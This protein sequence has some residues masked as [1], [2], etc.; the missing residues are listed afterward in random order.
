MDNFRQAANNCELHN[1]PFS[2]YEFTFDNGQE[3]VDNV[4]CRLDR[5]LVNDGWLSVFD[6]ARGVNLDREWSDHAPIK[7]AMAGTEGMEVKRDKPFR[8]EQVWVGEEKCEKVIDEAW[9]IGGPTVANKLAFCAADLKA[10]SDKEFG[11]KFRELRKKRKKLKELNKGGL[12]AAQ[13]ENRRKI[14]RDIADLLFP[15]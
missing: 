5:A 8:F 1:I 9:L 10:W 14:V 11:Q 4:Q 13:L 6:K 3:G 12:T 15:P 2:G 7:I